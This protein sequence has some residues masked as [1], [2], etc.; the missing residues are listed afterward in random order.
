MSAIAV[1][2]VLVGCGD[3]PSKE[4]AD[5]E[6]AART[7]QLEKRAAQEMARPL[8]P[9]VLAAGAHQ[10]L[11]LDVPVRSTSYSIDYRRCIVWRDLEFK[12]AALSCVEDVSRYDDDSWKDAGRGGE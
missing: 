5:K 2:A 6:A 12:T 3:R 8:K 7:A 1:L 10:V 11:V 4:H 9:R